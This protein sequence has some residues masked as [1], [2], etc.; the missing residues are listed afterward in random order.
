MTAAQQAETI[1]APVVLKADG[2]QLLHKTE[3]GGVRV[4]L[5]TPA[6]VASAFDS[7]RDT[8][9][10]AMEGAVIQPMVSGGV[11]TIVGFVRDPSFGPLVLFGLGGTAAELLGDNVVRLAPLTDLDAS[12]MVTGIRTAPLLTG[13]RG[14]EP[15]DVNALSDVVLRLG[16][17]A[18]DLPEL[19]EADCNP[20]VA[21]PSGPVVVDARIRVAPE[22]GRAAPEGARHLA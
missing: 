6:E 18:E 15:V 19:I 16:Q 13:F 8:I 4:G 1:G 20:V 2:P 3:H 22:P 14:S 10:P 12:E 21:T 5:A 11:E 7:M 17:L 9:G